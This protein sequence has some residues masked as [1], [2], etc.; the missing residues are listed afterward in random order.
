MNNLKRVLTTIAALTCILTSVSCSLGSDKESKQN[1][2]QTA[3]KVI[4]KAYQAIDVDSDI[5]LS[6]I[7]TV[8]P[9]GDT[10]NVFISGYGENGNEMYIT[11]MEFLTFTPVDLDMTIE[12]NAEIYYNAV[13]TNDGTIFAI[14]SITDYGDFELPDYDDPDFD[15]EN[16]DYEAMEKAAKMSYKLYILD[17]EGKVISENEITGIEKYQEEENRLYLNE[18][19]S[20][21]N[22]KIILGISGM[23]DM[24]YVT[25]NSD[26]TIGEELD[27]GDDSWLYPVGNDT[28]GNLVY[29]TYEGD[30][31]V[32]KTFEAET[33]TLSSDTIP[34]KDADNNF[35]SI[36]KGSGDYRIYLSGSSSLFGLKSDGTLEEI[37]NWI[38]SDLTGDYIENII[39]L[40]EGDFLVFENDWSTNTTSIYRLT[41]RDA[42][43]LAN[44]QV[45]TMVMQYSNMD[46]MKQVKEFNKTNT[47]YRI[48]VEDY[49]KYYEWD[50]ESEKQT[51]S[52]AKQLKQDIAAGKSFDIICMNGNLS[53]FDNLSSKG[54]LVDLYEYMGKDGTVSKDDIIAPALSAGEKNGKLTSISTSFY[55][56]TYAAKTKYANKENWTVDDLI[57]T[58][59]NLPDGM[60]LLKGGNT[61]MDVF[62]L[63]MEGS[64][65][66][67]DYE[68]GTCNFDSPEFIKILEFCNRFDNEGEGDEIDW[69]TATNEEMNAYWEEQEVLC[70]NDKALLDSVYISDFREYARAE[71]AI[72]G[73][74]IT[75]VGYPSETGNGASL[76]FDMSYAIMSNSANKDACWK[77]ISQ[78]FEEDYQTSDGVI[79]TLKTAFE[80]TLDK[81]MEKPYWTDPETG[82][83]HEYDD[84]Y[85]MMGEEIQIKP[86][87][88]EKRDYLEQY[89]L[90][91]KA[92][93][94]Y[95]DDSVYP[96][97]NEEI[98]AF[99]AGEKSAQETAEL[100][101]NRVS[102]VVSEQS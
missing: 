11:D 75:L 28:D 48:K 26:G 5:P 22:D 69:E 41:K 44:T 13:V 79:P 93:R 71:Q 55:L 59:N 67:I 88:Q 2:P 89:V 57:E 45:I 37:V 85:Y 15:Y 61:K 60:K 1:Q 92:S 86:L 77:F 52:P 12:G 78:L 42:S 58:Y 53:L 19:Y 23:S 27:F 21:G 83:K 20:C 97:I 36:I 10:G 6:S 66:F 38:D 96:I 62:S 50:E 80:K 17:S 7:R 33:M 29:T 25:L 99:F 72:F 49:N 81:A 3:D 8:S 70:R 18:V 73:D 102:I 47:E 31:S 9:L 16:F 63:F 94:F 54:A 84:S 35:Q 101:Q 30:G 14:G 34:L 40:E 24:K 87:T 64:M 51:N 76:N 32:V 100:I 4:D 98:E 90:N 56:G 82:E 91:A 46:V 43:E 68:K 95:Y 39:P 74:D 65:S